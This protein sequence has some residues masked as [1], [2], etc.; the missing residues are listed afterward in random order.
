MRARPAQIDWRTWLDASLF[1]LKI[2]IAITV[3]CLVG[4][5]TRLQHESFNFGDATDLGATPAGD[6]YIF[7]SWTTL[8]YF[9]SAITLT[10]GGFVQAFF[11]TRRAAIW[12]ISFAVIGLI[13]GVCLIGYG[14]DGLY[15][16]ISLMSSVV[17]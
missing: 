11:S 12:S 16:E 9:L 1:P 8:A 2:F 17:R 15:E 10:I 7:A 5:H 14:N 4:W 6:F 3:F 13:I